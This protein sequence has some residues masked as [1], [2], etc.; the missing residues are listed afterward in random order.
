MERNEIV[1]MKRLGRGGSESHIF[2]AETTYCK[3]TLSLS[4]LA[5]SNGAEQI[6]SDEVYVA[7]RA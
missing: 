4:G 2:G 6:C 1:Q 7:L 3:N 5:I